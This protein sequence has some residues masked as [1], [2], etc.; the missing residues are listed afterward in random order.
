MDINAFAQA[1]AKG[2]LFDAEGDI[3]PAQKIMELLD[4]TTYPQWPVK[5]RAVR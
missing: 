3:V 4:G 2:E 1:S 5:R